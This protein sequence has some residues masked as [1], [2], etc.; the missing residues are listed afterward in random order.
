M[1][2]RAKFRGHSIHFDE[3]SQ[4]W[5]YADNNPV[6]EVPWSGRKGRS[7]EECGLSTTPE[8][9]DGCLGKLPNVSFA[10][11]GHGV[12]AD[13]YIQYECDTPEHQTYPRGLYGHEAVE[14]LD[15][16]HQTN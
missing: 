4:E 8:G 6:G 16:H 13:A 15:N 7:C 5:R 12:E 2:A 3:D 10:C 11:C 9:Y 1:T 14:V